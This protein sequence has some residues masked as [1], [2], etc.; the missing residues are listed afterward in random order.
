MATH[1]STTAHVSDTGKER[2]LRS[3]RRSITRLPVTSRLP[4]ES[5]VVEPLRQQPTSPIPRHG[6][7]GLIT[8]SSTIANFGPPTRRT[9]PPPSVVQT[10]SPLAVPS[11]S[12]NYSKAQALDRRSIRSPPLSTRTPSLVSASTLSIPDSPQSA[13]RRKAS[14]INR[15]A[16]RVKTDAETMQDHHPL[17]TAHKGR[18]GD[19]P[20]PGAIFG[21]T[22]PHT[23]G[24]SSS[25]IT[26]RI[27]DSEVN[28]PNVNTEARSLHSKIE[29]Q[30]LFSDVASS[31]HSDS[32]FSHHSTPTPVSSHTSTAVSTLGT[33]RRRD[34]LELTRSAV[35]KSQ[36]QARR[37]NKLHIASAGSKDVTKPSTLGLREKLHPVVQQSKQRPTFTDPFQPK[38]TS[39]HGTKASLTSKSPTRKTLQRSPIVGVPPEFAHLN[40]DPPQPSTSAVPPRRPSRDGIASLGLPPDIHIVQSNL[41]H[42]TKA[43]SQGSTGTNPAL[44]PLSPRRMFGFPHRN[45]SSQSNTSPSEVACPTTPQTPVERYDVSSP[46]SRRDSPMAGPSPDPLGSNRT[47]ILPRD[48]KNSHTPSSSSEKPKKGP[49][50]GTGHEGYGK[51]GFRGRASSIFGRTSRSSS[52]ESSTSRKGLSFLS[53]KKSTT[54]EN[55]E[56]VDQF[57]EKRREPIILRGNKGVLR[58]EE[59]STPGM[60]ELFFHD[61]AEHHK[62]LSRSGIPASATD[63]TKSSLSD[64]GCQSRDGHWLS[65]STT[66][67][68]STSTHHANSQSTIPSLG[69]A[70]EKKQKAKPLRFGSIDQATGVSL[71]DVNTLL[72]GESTLSQDPQSPDGDIKRPPLISYSRR[73]EGL[74]PTPPNKTASKPKPLGSPVLLQ[75]KTM[76]PF[77]APQS[78]EISKTAG[79]THQSSISSYRLQSVGRIPQV[80]RAGQNLPPSHS[81]VVLEAP[82]KHGETQDKSSASE[83][84][85]TREFFAFPPRKDSQLWYTSS[86]GL[87]STHIR[88]TS[89]VGEDEVWKEYDNLIDE[90]LPSEARTSATSSLGAPF[91]YGDMVDYKPGQNSLLPGTE[92]NDLDMGRFT[93]SDYLVDQDTPISPRHVVSPQMAP[94]VLDTRTKRTSIRREVKRPAD[95]AASA[96]LRFAALMTSKWLS[97]GRLLFSPAHEEALSA[98]HARILIIDGLGKEWSYNCA[99]TYPNCQFYNLGPEPNSSTWETLANYHHVTHSSACTPFPFPNNYF[100]AVVLRFPVAAADAAYQACFDEIKRTLRPSGYIELSVL[101]LDLMKMGHTARKTVRDLKIRMH[102]NDSDVSLWNHGDAF[103]TLLGKCGFEHLH[104]CVVGIP[105][106]GRIRKSRDDGK[107]GEQVD[108]DTSSS[109][110]QQPEQAQQRKSTSSGTLST[111][112]TDEPEYLRFTE[113]MQSSSH[114]QNTTTT[115]SSSATSPLPSSLTNSQQQ[116]QHAQEEKTDT[117]DHPH[118]HHRSD[119]DIT[120]TVAKIGR[121][122]YSS[123][124]PDPAAQQDQNKAAGEEKGERVGNIWDTPGL[125][126][127]CE[128]QGTKF[129]LLFCYARKPGSGVRRRTVSV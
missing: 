98:T 60:N 18:Y 11:V 27:S 114:H 123:C 19:D 104:K 81:A 34:S 88:R 39:V 10:Q 118:T 22:L 120:K 79:Q 44:T 115:S 54:S 36:I 65:S 24:P 93:I 125:L 2:Q 99:L 64:L 43:P 119:E 96:E 102:L 76:T 33:G 41:T 89:F 107:D 71:T 26:S 35:V 38:T 28:T 56:D 86:S 117:N 14:S 20:Y 23:E 73:H 112:T 21:M 77:K 129:R 1:S 69:S 87:E 100:T 62:R 74:L 40:V 72:T 108:N 51:F 78:V 53:R 121:W 55:E 32:P 16:L 31:R 42:I 17:V 61:Q 7:K 52:N 106:A 48:H 82:L 92:S 9:M 49:A 57:L 110:Q 128:G 97:F 58:P 15:Y 13:L 116:Q 50:A 30:A 124:Y 105:V 3:L 67:R 85:G 37:I 94:A 109:S 68:A 8:Q 83:V 6:P 46:L 25:N 95:N 5:S 45:S 122:W 80:M 111:T 47:S 12:G 101:D 103:V 63:S 59:P 66:N 126:R 75:A 4:K 29:L 113:W 91:Q 70:L 127:E 84:G 90:V